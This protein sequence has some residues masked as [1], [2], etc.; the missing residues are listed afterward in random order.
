MGNRYGYQPFPSR[1]GQE[2][3]ELL[4]RIA[5]ESDEP[6]AQLLKDWFIKDE[7]MVPPEYILQV[8]V[9]VTIL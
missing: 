3:F 2:E 8:L 5:E 6:G 1:I 7:N 4:L 9:H